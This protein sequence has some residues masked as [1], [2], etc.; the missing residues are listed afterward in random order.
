MG[1]LAPSQTT[2]LLGS[3]SWKALGSLCSTNYFCYMSTEEWLIILFSS[4]PSPL[5]MMLSTFNHHH[6]KGCPTTTVSLKLGLRYRS[7][8]HQGLPITLYNLLVCPDAG[9]FSQWM[10]LG[11]GQQSGSWPRCSCW[12]PAYELA[13]SVMAFS[14]WIPDMP[15]KTLQ[16][17]WC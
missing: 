1:M 7:A 11:H 16:W 10:V 15:N 2:L 4:R 14:L 17:K 8:Q 5:D 3:D 6:F 12:Y 13:S 9:C